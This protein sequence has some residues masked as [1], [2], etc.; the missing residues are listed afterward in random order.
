[1]LKRRDGRYWPRQRSSLWRKVN[2]RSQCSSV[3]EVV[4]SDPR[5]GGVER[6]GCRVPDQHRALGACHWR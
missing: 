4:S 3:V 1:M 2:A 5:S 6:V